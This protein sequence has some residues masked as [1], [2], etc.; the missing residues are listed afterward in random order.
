MSYLALYRKYRPKAFNEMI[1]QDHI[2][3][4]LVNQIVRDKVAH[5]YLFS[6]SR[7][8]GKTTAAKVFAK[9][10]NCE[11]R[12]GSPCGVCDS[13]KAIDGG[14]TDVMEIDAASNNGVGEIR[15][16][17]ETVR[18]QPSTGKYRVFIIDEVHMLSGAAFNALLKTLEEPP[19][20]VIFILATTDP[21]K[22]PATILSRCLKF[23]FWLVPEAE[24]E[25]HIAGILDA[26]GKKYDKE[27]VT[28]IA[29][30]GEGSVRDAL[31]IA[32]VCISMSEGK[33]T[34]GDV[35]AA[36]GASKPEMIYSLADSIIRGETA[37]FFLK[38][39]EMVTL[40]KS[41]GILNK[42][43]IK[44][45]RDLLIVMT[46]SDGNKILRLP[47]EVFEKLSAQAKTVSKEAVAAAIDIFSR[48]EAD[49]RYSSQQRLL[50]ENACVKASACK[51][52]TEIENKLNALSK[53][54][55]ELRKKD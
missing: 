50:F 2:V 14:S 18:Y 10:V 34:Y 6:G 31:S 12:G 28:A 8:T 5:A 19:E 43:I 37:G 45:F 52:G 16:L 44:H 35:L 30:A 36:L 7:G 17:R 46:V 22:V 53:E 20:H 13:C 51:S 11:K 55:E 23:D 39:D 24:L 9:S 32:D 25:K 1:G 42:D 41:I 21:Q 47:K 48:C 26:E 3:K 27:A 15:N 54:V 33:L 49:M 40:G 4:V 29:R 38:I